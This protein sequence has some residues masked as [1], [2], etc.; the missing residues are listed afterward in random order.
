MTA[1]GITLH[2]RLVTGRNTH[3]IVEASFK[4]VARCLRGTPSGSRAAASRPPRAR[5]DPPARPVIAVL[6]YGIGNLRSAE[7]ALQHVGADARL[8]ADPDEAAGGRRRSCCPEWAPSAGAPQPSSRADSTTRPATPS[9]RALPF[10]GI[11]VGFQL[12]YEGSEEDPSAAGLGVLAGMVRR[13]PD[14][15][16]HPQM[17]WNILDVGTARGSAGRRARPGLGLLRPLLRPRAHRRHHGHLRL[18]RPGGGRR[19]TGPVWGTQFHPE[20]SGSVGLG[21]LANF[22]AAVDG[23]RPPDGPVPGHRHPRRWRGPAHPGRLRPPERL[24]RPGGP[25]RAG[26]SAGG[27]PWL[28]VVDLD[29][30]RTGR[31]GQ[32]GD[33]AG[34]RPRRRCAGRDRWGGAHARRCR[35]AA[36]RRCD[37]CRPRNRRPLDD[38][39]LVRRADA[40]PIPDG[41][42]LG[43]DYRRDRRRPGRGGGPGV[44][45]GQR[46]APW[47]RCST[48]WRAP[49][50]PPWSSPP[51]SATARWPAPTS[52]A[53]A[54]GAGLDRDP[55][56]RL[57][58][59]RLGGRH[60][61]AGRARGR[62]DHGRGRGDWPG[63]SR[64][65]RWSTGG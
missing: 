20:K 29:A 21:I 43:L 26:S 38:P 14:G 19:R 58:W 45:A 30:A 46:A 25:R 42:P 16:K 57:G 63:P 53:C 34:H 32:P 15:V 52:T 49:V 22:V 18:R 55:R 5:C 64:A 41:S 36:R 39:G 1:A 23:H 47:A 51:S 40:R 7:K 13:L 54:D 37:P 60:R 17:Q 44:G 10:L 8:V 62:G 56:D 31:T 65:R 9:A 28:H 33:G 2:V 24:R 6:D 59:R 48:R 50:W 35:R 3:H 11:C 4:A 61:G 27:A 12:L